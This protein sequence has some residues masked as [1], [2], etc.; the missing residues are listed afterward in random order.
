MTDAGSDPRIRNKANLTPAALVDP[1]NVKIKQLLQDA[2][3][4][5][6]NAGDFVNVEE[7][8]QEEELGDDYA[9]SA[10]DSDF[11]AEEYRRE[12]ERMKGEERRGLSKE[13]GGMI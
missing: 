5:Q 8:G 13:N 2:I 12:R 6:Q 7:R 1:A 9:G 3:D 10:S 11:D 4:I